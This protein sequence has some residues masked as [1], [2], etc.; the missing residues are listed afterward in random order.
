MAMTIISQVDRLNYL[1]Y[2]NYLTTITSQ[3]DR[4]NYLNYLTNFTY[5]RQSSSQHQEGLHP[6]IPRRFTSRNTQK[7]YILQYPEGLHP[8][9]PGRFTSRNTQKVYI[10]QHQEG[11]HPAIPRRFTSRNTQKVYISQYQEGLH[12]AIPR[13]FTSRTVG[14][15][16]KIRARLNLCHL[17]FTIEQSSSL[18]RTKGYEPGDNQRHTVRVQLAHS[19]TTST[20]IR[21]EAAADLRLH[22]QP[23]FNTRCVPLNLGNRPKKQIISTIVV[24]CAS[25]RTT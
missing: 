16:A 2:L 11:L 24:T 25:H 21:R 7:V 4:L 19:S 12:L 5:F 20:Q 6:A 14:S 10:L 18:L 17:N 9:T 3:I 13:R 15:T 23:L 22:R 8:A 1:N